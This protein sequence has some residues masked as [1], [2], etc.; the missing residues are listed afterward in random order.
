MVWPVRLLTGHLRR[1]QMGDFVLVPTAMLPPLPSEYGRLLRGFNDLVQAVRERE[2]LTARLAERE[3]ESVLGRLAATVAHEVRNPLGGMATALDT[4]RKFG[5]DPQIRANGLD[6]IERGLCSIRDVVGSVL[7]FHRMPSDGR[8]LEAGD[9][10][11]LRLLIGPE[12]ARRELHLAWSSSV[13]GTFDIPATET[14]QI[15]LNLLLNACEASPQGGEIGFRACV[16]R[17]RA[18]QRSELII[19]VLDAG[20]GLPSDV[21]AALTDIG[22]TDSHDPPRGLGIRVVRNLVLGLGGRITAASAEGSRG[23][24]ITVALPGRRGAGRDIET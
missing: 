23:S 6:L 13:E 17:D 2:A 7:A 15:A 22:R 20:P 8:R 1:A 24:R 4:V 14:R 19:E 16:D 21:L 11:D 5:G 18:D 10:D 3:R 12:L 9:L